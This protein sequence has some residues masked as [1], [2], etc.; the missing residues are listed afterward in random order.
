M[1]TCVKSHYPSKIVKILTVFSLHSGNLIYILS[2]NLVYMLGI[3]VYIAWYIYN[4][5]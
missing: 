3:I 1:H 5:P 4:M 2:G